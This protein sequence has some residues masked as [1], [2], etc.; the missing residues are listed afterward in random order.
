MQ[1]HQSNIVDSVSSCKTDEN[2]ELFSGAP[3]RGHVPII[4]EL[5]ITNQPNT[6]Q[7]SE[8]LDLS[9]MNWDS[10][11]QSIE[12]EIQE[13]RANIEAEE[14][15]YTLWNKLNAIITKAT[16]NHGEKKKCTQYSKPYPE[17][18]YRQPESLT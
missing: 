8:K 5:K 1:L 18:S 12:T 4:T 15:P 9:K 11:S 2:V 3:T 13:N 6:E 14:N 16:D 7:Y 10:W 17:K